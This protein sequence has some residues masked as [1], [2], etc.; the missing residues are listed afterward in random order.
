MRNAL[1]G[2]YIMTRSLGIV[3]AAFV[4]AL[5]LTPISAQSQQISACVNNSSGTIHI[6]G[7]NGTCSS[8]ERLLTWNATPLGAS[9]F[10]CA[11][12]FNV[13]SS[14]GPL[15]PS[16]GYTAG[17]TFGS[18]I[19]YTPGGTTFMLQPGI[20]QVQLNVPSVRMFFAP[21]T[22]GTSSFNVRVLVNANLVTTFLGEGSIANGK[23]LVPVA[24][25]ELLQISAANTVVGFDVEFIQVAISSFVI[26]CNIIF[27]Q[28][29]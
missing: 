23:A 29:K 11:S 27:T 16:G 3:G 28:L 21:N 7:P 20:Y 14:G 1:T 9:Q 19:T 6:V 13:P 22:I 17:V 5:G 26:A 18:G 25:N 15:A 24:G 10:S 12:G 8:N 2:R 4:V